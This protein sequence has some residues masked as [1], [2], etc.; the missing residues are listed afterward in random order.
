MRKLL[1]V[2]D[3]DGV[4]ALVRMTLDSDNYQIFEAE[5][6][7]QALEVARANTPTSCCST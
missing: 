1:I 7:G 6:G 4:R 5:E 2:D 3:E